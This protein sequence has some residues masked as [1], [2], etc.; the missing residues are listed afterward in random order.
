M[1][2]KY[3]ILLLV[4]IFLTSTILYSNKKAGTAGAQFLKIDIGA[5]ASAIGGAYTSVTGNNYNIYYNPA[6]LVDINKRIITA[7]HNEWIDNVKYEYLAYS[8]RLSQYDAVGIALQ[9]LHTGSTDKTDDFGNI[10]G[11]FTAED[12]AVN[13]SY[14]YK[15]TEDIYLGITGKF[16]KQS[17]A[18][19]TATAPAVDLGIIFNQLKYEDITFGFSV[20]NIGNKIKFIKEGD[21]LPLIWRGGVN[22]LYRKTILFSTDIVKPID[23]D[24]YF[25]CGMEYNYYNMIFLRT[26]YVSN[27]DVDDGYRLGLG[28]N[29]HSIMFDYAFVPQGYFGD[30]HRFSMSYEF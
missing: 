8:L 15:W 5:R 4:M 13:I 26:G 16:I 28:F 30:S 6:G 24:V 7:H 12:I 25:A 2:N 27:D 22:Y 1:K 23:N 20:S 11:S 21:R 10:I 17:N 19:Y 9:Y 18:G 29:I 14:A 3:Y